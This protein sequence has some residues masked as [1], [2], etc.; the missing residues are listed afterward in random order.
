MAWDEKPTTLCHQVLIQYSA[1]TMPAFNAASLS[2]TNV[3][4]VIV[5]RLLLDLRFTKTSH[6]LLV[7]NKIA[8]TI[9]VCSNLYYYKLWA[10][11]FPT[12][13]NRWFFPRFWGSTSLLTLQD[14]FKYPAEFSQPLTGG[15]SLDS[16][17][18]LDSFLSRTLSSILRGLPNH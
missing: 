14:S 4:A 5:A 13:C 7:L 12:S 1:V 2:A 9:L 15:F 17:W 8:E 11:S 16:E 3:P 6:E 18:L 10:W